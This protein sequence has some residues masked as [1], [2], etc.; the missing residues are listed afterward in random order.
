MSET[1]DPG[2]RET[3]GYEFSAERDARAAAA[4][5]DRCFGEELVELRVY[6]IRWNG[7]YL[8]EATFAPDTPESSVYSARAHLGESG[9]PV[10]DDD[11]ADYKKGL[12][13]G[14][15]GWFRRVFGE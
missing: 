15:G 6:R 12:R 14:I 4:E 3:L 2:P 7:N 8:V 5:L 13:G 9:S 10:H 11:L 1:G